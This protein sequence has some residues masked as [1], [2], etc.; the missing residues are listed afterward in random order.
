MFFKNE[1]SFALFLKS[2]PN[3]L[4]GLFLYANFRYLYEVKC[5]DKE[6]NHLFCGYMV[7]QP[8]LTVCSKEPFKA[9]V[10]TYISLCQVTPRGIERCFLVMDE[11]FKRIEP[12]IGKT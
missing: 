7:G 6:P 5:E 12:H 3:F 11:F 8:I 2:I 9:N 10:E 1:L 4:G